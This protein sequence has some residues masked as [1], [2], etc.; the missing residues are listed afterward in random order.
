MRFSYYRITNNEV[1][2]P[3]KLKKH[4]VI[5]R[6]FAKRKLLN[7]DG[8]NSDGVLSISIRNSHQDPVGECRLVLACCSC[9]ML[10][11]IFPFLTAFYL[12]QD[13]I[14]N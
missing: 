8:L 13:L 14:S 5:A 6:A 7:S 4:K 9:V 10:L 2:E 11:V 1:E 12:L 3:V